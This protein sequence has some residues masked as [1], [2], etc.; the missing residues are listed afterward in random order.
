MNKHSVNTSFGVL[1][2]VAVAGYY[3][4]TAI[5][6]R[7]LSTNNGV[8]E[9]WYLRFG[10][11]F[12]VSLII[13][14]KKIIYKKFLHL[15]A[16][17]WL[18]LFFRVITGSI[19]AVALY[20]L[21]AQQAKIGP[22]AFMQAFPSMAILSIIMMKEKLTLKKGLLVMFSFLGVIIVVIENPHDLLNFN[23]GEIYSLISGIFFAF[24]FITR[25]W[26]TG[27]LNNQEITVA[28][29]GM[30][31]IA[32]YI[33]SLFLYHH[34][35]A[36]TN[37]WSILFIAVLIFAGVGAVGNIFLLNYGFE[38]VSGIIAGNIMNLEQ[39][40]GPIFGYIF[41]HELLSSREVI[42]GIIIL[43][44]AILM[45]MQNTKE[46]TSITTPD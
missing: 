10:I 28:L 44:A 17:E 31:F 14:R 33:L 45:N 32:N 4:I 38:R 9:Q 37:Q 15:P 46:I 41:Y 29:L 6:A 11:A 35:F 1:A 27:K 16:K 3:G 20:T 23:I 24:M 2:L 19:A 26:H 18:V 39:I 7:Y 22:V 21:A 13:F 12:F 43:T 40:F 36:N 30:G 34:L 42:G 5:L 25:K 8:F